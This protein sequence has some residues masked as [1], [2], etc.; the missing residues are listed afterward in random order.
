MTGARTSLAGTAQR[1]VRHRG[2]LLS[3]QAGKG[4]VVGCRSCTL[5]SLIV[6]LFGW[7]VVRL[8]ACSVGR[9]VDWFVCMC[10]CLLVSAF[11]C[12]FGAMELEF[13]GLT[14]WDSGVCGHIKRKLSL[15]GPC[16][17]S[18]FPS[19]SRYKSIEEPGLQDPT[20]S[21]LLHLILS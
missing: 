10:V 9:L 18:I 8:V 19:G 4:A 20:Y 11:C 3:R 1:S 14:V 2:I 13:T 6:C 21:E 12:Y 16:P 17:T 7:L 5:V 15:S